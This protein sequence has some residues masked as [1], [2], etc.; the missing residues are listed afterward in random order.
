[1][2]KHIGHAPSVKELRVSEWMWVTMESSLAD[3]DDTVGQSACPRCQPGRYALEHAKHRLAGLPTDY[4]D[5]IA[6]EP[7]GFA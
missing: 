1:M 5:A 4:L 2:T 6:K 7:R 3:H